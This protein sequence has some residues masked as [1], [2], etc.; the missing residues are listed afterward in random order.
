MPA[1]SHP[2]KTV[3]G[4]RPRWH[5]ALSGGGTRAALL[6]GGAL[7]ALHEEEGRIDVA[8][9]DAVSGSS[10]LLTRLLLAGESTKEPGTG[11]QALLAELTSIRRSGFG[12]PLRPTRLLA[13]FVV[14][15][16]GAYVIDAITGPVEPLSSG[17]NIRWPRAVNRALFLVPLLWGLGLWAMTR[18]DPVRFG[19]R[20]DRDGAR[21][22]FSHHDP[23]PLRTDVE[24]AGVLPSPDVWF[25]AAEV[26]SSRMEWFSPY[27]DH[28]TLWAGG[29]AGPMQMALM[30]AAFPGLT[31][32]VE[33]DGRRYI[34]GGALDLLALSRLTTQPGRPSTADV[35]PA[36]EPATKVLSIDA[37]VD[38]LQPTAPDPLRFRLRDAL[39]V[40]AQLLVVLIA[41]R[42]A[43]AFGV[44]PVSVSLLGVLAVTLIGFRMILQ[45]VSA[46]VLGMKYE[47]GL[48][49]RVVPMLQSTQRDLRIDRAK[50]AGL[51][52]TTIELRASAEFAPCAVLGHRID[53]ATK[54]GAMKG[55]VGADLV[56]FGY[57]E[58]KQ[59]LGAEPW[60]STLEWLEDLR[61]QAGPSAPAVM[62][63]PVRGAV[64]RT[65]GRILFRPVR[66]SCTCRRAPLSL[67]Q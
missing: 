36:A 29:R 65:L 66:P 56:R 2:P 17:V 41:L 31:P 42:A 44:D 35:G 10:L 8:S 12:S 46:L 1:E 14:A 3:D 62:L 38:P 30:S 57:V 40:G 60:P 45:G 22:F 19:R 20:R 26:E 4:V 48:E 24:R 50:A 5:V 27:Q 33:V 7:L 52:L 43:L 18:A 11:R 13:T 63:G 37:S 54:L 64:T 61:R 55:E 53:L 51:A 49:A 32:A 25:G 16:V 59:V 23:A 47:L 15:L 21:S 39:S 6:S 28:P 58:V 34:D 67:S 9:I